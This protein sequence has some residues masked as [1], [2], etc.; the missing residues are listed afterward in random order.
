[1]PK[2]TRTVLERQR[3]RGEIARYH[4]RRLV[5][6]EIAEIMNNAPPGTR[7]YTVTDDMVQRDI[8][9]L[10]EEWRAQR[11]TIDAVQDEALAAIDALE[12]EYWRAWDASL[13][14]QES[15]VQETLRDAEK[16]VGKRQTKNVIRAR[17]SKAPGGG[18]PAFLAGVQWCIAKRC[19]ILGLDRMGAEGTQAAAHLVLISQIP[20]LRLQDAPLAEQT[21]ADV[22]AARRA[23]LGMAPGTD[24]ARTT[25]PVIDATAEPATTPLADSAPT[26]GATP[27][28][29][30]MAQI[31]HMAAHSGPQTPGKDEDAL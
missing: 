11:R 12:R 10:R 28:Q 2:P 13:G 3:D 8:I 27:L 15:T 31:A 16:A 17:V 6:W 7:D 22:A 26:A 5:S 20:G 21:L 30:A 19:S 14:S 29:A 25:A 18:N 9:A 1:M 23:A 4:L 24:P